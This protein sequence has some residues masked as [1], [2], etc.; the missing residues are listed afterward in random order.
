MSKIYWSKSR[1]WLRGGMNTGCVSVSTITAQ[2]KQCN[3]VDCL[4]STVWYTII[5]AQSALLHFY[6]YTLTRS[7]PI[8]FKWDHHVNWF[9]FGLFGICVKLTVRFNFIG[10][11]FSYA[12]EQTK[13]ENITTKIEEVHKLH[14]WMATIHCS[15]LICIWHVSI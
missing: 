3:F 10:V 11:R 5:C 9:C 15:I 14:V 1:N 12:F 8:L 7:L 2:H 4:F 6:L 13:I